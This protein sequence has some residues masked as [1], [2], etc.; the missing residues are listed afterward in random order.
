M[1]ISVEEV[2]AD[3]NDRLIHY[4]Y[5]VKINK[6]KEPR[7]PEIPPPEWERY[8]VVQICIIIGRSIVTN[9]RRTLVVVIVVY[10]RI[11]GISASRLIIRSL[12]GSISS[13]RQIVIRHRD[14]KGL[15]CL[16]ISN[17]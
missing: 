6:N 16:A 10:Y 1:R 13:N 11:I 9:R 17:R 8:P 14:V 2:V 7:E 15:K 5:P 3:N 4:N 12:T